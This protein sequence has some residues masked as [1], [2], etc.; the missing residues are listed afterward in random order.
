MPNGLI[1]DPAGETVVVSITSA[2][3]GNALTLYSDANATTATTNPLTITTV[4]TV[5]VRET[6]NALVSLKIGGV[7]FATLSGSSLAYTFEDGSVGSCG[8]VK[9]STIDTFAETGSTEL[10]YAERTSNDTTTNTAYASS[11]SNKISGLSVTVV[12]Q[13]LPVLV[14]FFCPG[15]F[16]S[17]AA[18]GVSVTLITNGALTSGQLA[19]VDSSATNKSRALVM[20]RRMVLTAGTSYTFEV[21]KYV[22]AAG[23]GTYTAVADA[24]MHLSVNR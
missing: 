2:G 13:G 10:G 22:D 20:R 4:T 16:H 5:Y 12:G 8:V 14:E 21:G 18:T 17:V 9:R 7:E 3:G 6:V 15:V 19:T 23:T 24:P 11:T 1:I